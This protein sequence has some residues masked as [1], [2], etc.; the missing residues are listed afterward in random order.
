[1]LQNPILCSVP[2]SANAEPGLTHKKDFFF[3][4]LYF[5]YCDS[6]L[7]MLNTFTWLDSTLWLSLTSLPQLNSLC[8]SKWLDSSHCIKITWLNSQNLLSR[9]T[10]VIK[11]LYMRRHNFSS[12]ANDGLTIRVRCSVA[13]NLQVL[14]PRY[15]HAY[16]WAHTR[17]SNHANDVLGVILNRLSQAIVW[18]WLFHTSKYCDSYTS[19]LCWVLVYKVSFLISKIIFVSFEAIMTK[20]LKI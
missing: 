17:V 13:A 18:N 15:P 10:S 4:L 5:L 11:V 14:L 12:L 9:Y 19:N 1:M 3:S 20:T 16:V 6:N 8:Y 2:C 7:L